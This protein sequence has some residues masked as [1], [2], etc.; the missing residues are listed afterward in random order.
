ML[1]PLKD[2]RD[3]TITYDFQK[4]FDESGSKPKKYW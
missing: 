3:V 2:K 1:I 4:T